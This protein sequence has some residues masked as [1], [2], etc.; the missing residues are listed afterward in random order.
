MNGHSQLKQSDENLRS[1]D[2]FIPNFVIILL[3]KIIIIIFS[4]AKTKRKWS[5]KKIRET[6]QKKS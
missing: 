4:D 2:N 6:T 5:G 3:R 1:E